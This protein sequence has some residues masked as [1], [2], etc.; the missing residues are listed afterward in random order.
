MINVDDR[1]LDQLNESEIYLCLQIARYM[2]ASRMTAWPS[3]E[4]LAERC[5]WDER[6]VK[7]WRKSLEEKG[8]LEVTRTPGKSPTYQFKKSGFSVF[9]ALESVEPTAENGG[10]KNVPPAQSEGVQ[11]MSLEGVQNLSLEGVQNLYPEV[12]S[13]QEV[14]SNDEVVNPSTADAAAHVNPTQSK[15]SKAP[16]MAAPAAQKSPGWT[17]EWATAFDE[18]DKQKCEASGIPYDKFIWTVCPERSFSQLRN[19]REKAIIPSLT[20][21]RKREG[22]E[23]S[24]SEA[25]LLISARAVFS[26]A[27]D[28][29]QRIATETGGSRHYT[30]QSIYKNFNTLK[31]I[32]QQEY[33]ATTRSAPQS[34]T[35][36]GIHQQ[37][38][39]ALADYA[40]S[41][42]LRIIGGGQGGPSQTPFAPG[43]THEVE[44]IVVSTEFR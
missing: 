40:V 15:K 29:F 36:I 32:K 42:Q 5:K 8:F 14:I 38:H 3:I 35:R 28:Y 34:S 18:I 41:A 6:T 21:K 26:L 17:K 24:I 19:L 16:K 23:G 25:E 43:Y 44:G 11:K 10:T 7:R 9:H 33:A 4:T 22:K 30:P 31:T 37:H 2:K 39:N 27:W 1:V 12:V 20:E 13:S